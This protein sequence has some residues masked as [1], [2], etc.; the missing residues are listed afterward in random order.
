[1]K[2]STEHKSHFGLQ[3]DVPSKYR[4]K[5]LHPHSSPGST[6]PQTH[7]AADAPA[8]LWAPVTSCYQ[9]RRSFWTMTLNPQPASRPNSPRWVQII[10]NTKKRPKSKWSWHLRKPLG[11]KTRIYLKSN[12]S[13]HC[14]NNSC[15]HLLSTQVVGL[16]FKSHVPLKTWDPGFTWSNSVWWKAEWE[17][18]SICL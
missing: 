18:T 17:L 12:K 1:M 2:Y 4:V 5:E 16:L 15:T 3:T 6:W 10:S 14:Q 8:V 11:Q 13:P 7:G 9:V